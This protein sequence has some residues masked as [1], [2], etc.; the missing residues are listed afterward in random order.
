MQV[1]QRSEK[2]D[3]GLMASTADFM[4]SAD[5]QGL[6]KLIN[7]Y[8]ITPYENTS[9]ALVNLDDSSSSGASYSFVPPT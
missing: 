8:K 4:I 7:S 9:Q 2:I 1:I 6:P 3:G 5:W